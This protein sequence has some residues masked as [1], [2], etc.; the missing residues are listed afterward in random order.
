MIQGGD[1]NSKRAAAGIPLGSGDLGYRVPAEFRTTLFH[2]K[3]VIAA[4]RMGDEVNPQKA[5]SASQ[6]YIV[7]GKTFT[8]GGLDSLEINRLRGRKIPAAHREV[9]KTMGGTPHL[10]QGYTVFGE[11]IKGIEVVD[12]IAVVATSTAA[13]RD[14]PLQD[15][16]IIKAT[17][18]KR[19]KI[20][21][22][23]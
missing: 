17:L 6:F 10:D 11:V 13:D 18:I 22:K 9:Y 16:R 5:S 12:K 15:V 8:S 19:K 2:K 14:R 4:A 21:D 7:Q 1:P 23:K 20:K 3:G